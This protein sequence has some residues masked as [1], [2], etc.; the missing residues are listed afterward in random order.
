M[1]CWIVFLLLAIILWF[2]LPQSSQSERK[3]FNVSGIEPYKNDQSDIQFTN[4]EFKF[5]T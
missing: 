5:Y 2:I 1:Y 4:A 3:T